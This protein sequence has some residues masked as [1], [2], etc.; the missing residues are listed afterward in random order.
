MYLA[1]VYLFTALA[2]YLLVTE[3]ERI[4]GIRQAYLGNQATV[5]DR[6]IRL[7]GIP[8]SLRSEE[9]I[10]AFIERL[11]IGEVE[12]VTLCRQWQ[13]LDAM[14]DRRMEV[15]RKLEESWTV[16]LGKRQV[17]SD[18]YSMPP[19]RPPPALI[20]IEEDAYHDDDDDQERDEES[21]LGRDQNDSTELRGDTKS[22]PTTSIRY[23]FF[24]L[25]SRS[26]DAIDYYEEQLGEID[27]K[28]V[29]LRQ[30][31]FKPTALAFVTLDSV[32]ACVS[33][34]AIERAVHKC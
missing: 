9:K 22:R 12:S 24:G 30:Q 7:S 25:R 31:E 28:I 4:I 34:F 32:A 15:L 18:L 13:E 20:E 2:I 21:G 16:Y 8:D 29:E 33:P 19:S 10:K 6:T 14:L 23:G 11:Q 1:L 17:S 3:T 5:T 26:V 27:K